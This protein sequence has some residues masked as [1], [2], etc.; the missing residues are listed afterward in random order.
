MR[1]GESGRRD[2]L[3]EL[4]T[5]QRGYFTAAQAREAGYSYQAQQHHKMHGNWRL[6]D[7][8]IYRFREYN[9]LPG[10]DTDHLVRWTLWSGG[11]AVV[12]HV[13]ALAVH[14]LGIASPAE[15]H[16][17]VEAGFRRKEEA[18]VLHRAD[19]LPYE[20]EQHEGFRV[21]TPIRAVLET[22]QAGMD[23]DVVDS[24]VA[25][26]LDRGLSSRRRLLHGAQE[27]GPRAELAIERAL[28]AGRE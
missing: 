18:V 17:T 13:T 21:T 28:Q 15:I 26:L 6:I 1:N 11:K 9:A 27:I 22:A 7:R 23:Q 16:L 4:A 12:S 3:W 10:Q 8:G 19:L 25:E 14:D 24:A 20:I 2:R 5:R